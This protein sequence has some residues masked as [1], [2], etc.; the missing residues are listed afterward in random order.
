M[1]RLIQPSID[2]VARSRLCMVINTLGQG[3]FDPVCRSSNHPD[4]F[5]P[6]INRQ[7]MVGINNDLYKFKPSFSET[8]QNRLSLKAI[9]HPWGDSY[10]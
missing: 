10:V 8:N 2:S 7:L 4:Y 9:P 3:L 5:N 6:L 1:R